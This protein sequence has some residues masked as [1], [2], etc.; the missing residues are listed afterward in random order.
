MSDHTKSDLENS[1][2][3]LARRG[4]LA[5]GAAVAVSIGAPTFA[6]A[7]A[8]ADNYDELMMLIDQRDELA[9]LH[10][11]ACDM[12][13][14]IA[15]RD[16]RPGV[17]TIELSEMFGEEHYRK[18][19][20]FAGNRAFH[21]VHGLTTLGGFYEE[22]ITWAVNRRRINPEWSEW[23]DIKSR[24][25]DRAHAEL[26][27]LIAEREAWDAASGLIA[28]ED[29][30]GQIGA[31]LWDIEKRIF[32]T[33][34]LSSRDIGVKLDVVES[35][36]STGGNSGCEFELRMILNSMRDL[37]NSNC[38]PTAATGQH[39]RDMVTT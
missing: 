30:A 18:Y 36:F 3:S 9:T 15:N 8:V 11:I 34:C 4:F 14:T 10:E 12:E 20:P 26:S 25:F 24:D 2:V 17:P 21:G 31:Q 37:A 16:D 33:P 6:I 13:Q 39:G 35:W 19:Y 27:R 22:Q 28:A 7:A 5:G 29:E 23:P 32:T 38:C 1:S